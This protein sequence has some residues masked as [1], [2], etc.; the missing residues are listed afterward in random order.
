VTILPEIFNIET[1]LVLHIT[2]DNLLRHEVAC[3]IVS[4][5]GAS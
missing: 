5:H 3:V 2:T 4:N 1:A